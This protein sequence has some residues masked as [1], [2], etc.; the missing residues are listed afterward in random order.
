MR[1]IRECVRASKRERERARRERRERERAR[2]FACGLIGFKSLGFYQG[3]VL[4]DQG[5]GCILY[6]YP[7][8]LFK[9]ASSILLLC[10]LR[11]PLS[12]AATG[13]GFRV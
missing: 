3:S 5:L 1:E 4:R 2:A 10:S 13:L 12:D 6:R 7:Q 9:I 8:L 11:C